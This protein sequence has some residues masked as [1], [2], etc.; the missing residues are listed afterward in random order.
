VGAVPSRLRG[1]L[2]LSFAASIVASIVAC[3]GPANE[4]EPSRAETYQRTNPRE[5]IA[6]PGDTASS[7]RNMPGSGKGS[8]SPRGK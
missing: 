3:G 4:G 5:G 2:A 1:V 8:A 6:A 7:P